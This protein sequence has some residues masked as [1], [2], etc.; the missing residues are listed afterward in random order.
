MTMK[1][2]LRARTSYDLIAACDLALAATLYH[3]AEIRGQLASAPAKWWER[4]QAF[5][6]LP[7]MVRLTLEA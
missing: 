3:G 4:I 7:A 6:S 1:H 5:L 2:I